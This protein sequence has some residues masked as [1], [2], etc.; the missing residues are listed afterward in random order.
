MPRETN[1][2]LDVSNDDNNA[3][4]CTAFANIQSCRRFWKQ[5]YWRS[6]LGGRP[7]HIRWDAL[8]L[9][10]LLL[11]LLLPLSAPNPF[12]G[13]RIGSRVTARFS[14]SALYVVDLKKFRRMAAGDRLRGQY[15]GLS[16]DPNSLSNLDQV[17][18]AIIRRPQKTVRPTHSLPPPLPP[19]LPPALPSLP[20][21][22][23][24]PPLPS[25]LPPSLP[26]FRPSLPRLFTHLHTHFVT[27]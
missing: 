4:F 10:L 22:R 20:P 5:G 15:Q 25:S 3:S 26:P 18:A 8:P 12:V 13:K 9:S 27:P 7:Y 21:S 16:Q 11:L 19:S 6:H 17:G 2:R 1:K 23:P 14:S 24:L